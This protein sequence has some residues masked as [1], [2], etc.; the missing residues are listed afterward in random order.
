MLCLPSLPKG[1]W[2]ALFHL[3]CH[4]A[5]H[6]GMLTGSGSVQCMLHQNPCLANE[7]HSAPNNCVSS[8]FEPFKGFVLPKEC[9]PSTALQAC[10][11]SQGG[12]RRA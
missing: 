4:S 3:A 8:R 7:K 2:C 1:L 12:L 9:L 11:A 6:G 5:V 10:G